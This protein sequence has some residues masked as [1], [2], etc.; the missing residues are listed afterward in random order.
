MTNLH[1]AE[2]PSG[3]PAD[4]ATQTGWLLTR[5]MHRSGHSQQGRAVKRVD[6][7][8]PGGRV[9]IPPTGFPLW[10]I[11]VVALPST[12]LGAVMPRHVDLA[13]CRQG[14][15]IPRVD[16]FADRLVVTYGA[17]VAT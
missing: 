16:V 7:P 5:L 1:A 10:D 14:P 11:N 17:L 12:V 2:E 3:E 4:F 8:Y 9:V 6:C 15:M 13:V